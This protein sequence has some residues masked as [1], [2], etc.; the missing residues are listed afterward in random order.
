M[1]AWMTFGPT[2]EEARLDRPKR[3]KNYLESLNEKLE[4]DG[5]KRHQHTMFSNPG[6]V[7]SAIIVCEKA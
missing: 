1:M 7:S 2:I 5:E 6:G 3:P 4:R